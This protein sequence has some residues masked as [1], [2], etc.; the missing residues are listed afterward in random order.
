M[1]QQT[2]Y[3]CNNV[4][5][6]VNRFSMNTGFTLVEL[7]IAVAIAAVLATIALPAMNN[8]IETARRSEAK[9]ALLELAN[10]MERHYTMNSSYIT[11]NG[12]PPALPFNTVPKD[13]T[14][15]QTY[16][17]SVQATPQAYTLQAL[18]ITTGTQARDKCGTLTLNHT[19]ET[20][21]AQ[22]NCWEK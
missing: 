3:G 21:A 10:F 18:P 8:H 20:S 1:N 19:G 12:T 16:T 11:S 22:P 9:T 15:Q 6:S 17:L 2:M 7:M 13:T 4:K 5:N 14:S